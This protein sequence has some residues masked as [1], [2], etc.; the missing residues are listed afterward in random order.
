[1]K[2]TLSADDKATEGSVSAVT[3]LVSALA[4]AIRNTRKAA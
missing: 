2:A 4:A 1:L 3:E